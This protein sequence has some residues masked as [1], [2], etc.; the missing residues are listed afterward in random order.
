MPSITARPRIRIAALVGP[1]RK[2]VAQREL[3]KPLD[4]RIY[5]A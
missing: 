5:V 3:R 2:A 1:I 4:S